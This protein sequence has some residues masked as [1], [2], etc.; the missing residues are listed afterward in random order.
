MHDLQDERDAFEI[1][2]QG[3]TFLASIDG[4]RA[5]KLGD[6]WFFDKDE[7]G[8]VLAIKDLVQDY[9]GAET[10][11]RP[12]SIAVFG[13][14][15][16]GKSFA[17]RE[18]QKTM[19]KEFTRL[20]LTYSE[21]NLTQIPS[22]REL[23]H[24]IK[25]IVKYS[26]IAGATLEK[27]TVPFIFFDEFDAPCAGVPLGWLYWF[28]SPM[29]DSVVGHGEDRLV[30]RRAVYVFAGGTAHSLA[31]FTK[32]GSPQFVSAKGPDFVSRLRGYIDVRGPNHEIRTC[33]RR[34]I[35][36][37]MTLGNRSTQTD[38]YPDKDLF[39]RFFNQGRFRHGARSISVLLEMAEARAREEARAK[40]AQ[41]VGAITLEHLPPPHILSIHADQGP[42]DPRA[43]GGLIG[44]SIGRDSQ[45]QDDSK[46]ALLTTALIG[47]LWDYGATIGYG[48]R[49]N[50]QLTKDIVGKSLQLQRPTAAP[51][52]RVEVF[53]RDDKQPQEFGDGVL[54]IPIASYWPEEP[55]KDKA[56]NAPSSCAAAFRMRWAMSCRCAA[57]I[58][59]GGPLEGFSGRMPG[60]LEEAVLAL[61]LG[62]LVYV[63]G[64]Q[65][66][67]STMIGEL[68]GL[69]TSSSPKR[70]GNSV[71]ALLRSNEGVDEFAV[72]YPR[73]FRPLPSLPLTAMEAIEFVSSYHIGGPLWSDNGLSL[74]ENR[75][76][77]SS[78]TAKDVVPLVLQ[79]LQRR[80]SGLS[81]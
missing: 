14:P 58:F 31:D 42:L 10:T 49:W 8:E 61:A 48:G 62:Q 16:S 5:W 18:I 46:P 71:H 12:L 39:F 1:V 69:S 34:A 2:D 59:V 75:R 32:V 21:L 74:E 54:V 79:G 43:I 26:E 11:K 24:E 67:A 6:L 52:V 56:R 53:S 17:V 22:P 4:E 9:L 36:M 78:E 73:L 28:L 25:N 35:V 77:F 19:S 45:N 15:G 68:L 38:C 3:A 20:H 57:R 65:G 80:M 33:S 37:R 29:Q 27:K 40:G 50:A 7:H 66:G 41:S 55:S 30:L 47:R 63:V 60:I 81:R 23:F 51:Q 13:P 70:I 44:I 72:S 76:L 64:S